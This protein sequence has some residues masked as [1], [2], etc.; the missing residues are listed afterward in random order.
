MLHANHLPSLCML[1]PCRLLVTLANECCTLSRIGG[2][3]QAAR[4]AARMCRRAL[5]RAL[6]PWAFRA[7]S[8]SVALLRLQLQ[9][10]RY[11][12]HSGCSRSNSRR[13]APRGVESQEAL[14]GPKQL[15]RRNNS[16][17]K[18]PD[19]YARFVNVRGLRLE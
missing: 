7:N 10:K 11:K 16:R 9:M 17:Q 13:F 2:L 4:E 18:G 12:S 8:F 19:G 5:G 3:Q 1:L 15:K 6:Y 14:S